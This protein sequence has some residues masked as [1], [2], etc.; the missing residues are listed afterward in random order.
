MFRIRPRVVALRRLRLAQCG[1]QQP[2]EQ[3]ADKGQHAA[4]QQDVECNQQ[5][6]GQVCDLPIEEAEYT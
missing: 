4:H 6:V 5:Y 1:A 3:R 2:D